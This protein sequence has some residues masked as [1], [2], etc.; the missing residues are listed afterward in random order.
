MREQE[1]NLTSCFTSLGF[2]SFYDVN[3]IECKDNTRYFLTYVF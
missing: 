2:L 3:M 1:T